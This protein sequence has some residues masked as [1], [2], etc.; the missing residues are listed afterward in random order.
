ML[1]VKVC[2]QRLIKQQTDMFRA[3]F[4]NLSFNDLNEHIIFTITNF[5]INF[6]FASPINNLPNE[7]HITTHNIFHQRFNNFKKRNN[8]IS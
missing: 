2:C 3:L 1:N 4:Y 8:F 6:P 5:R 7:T